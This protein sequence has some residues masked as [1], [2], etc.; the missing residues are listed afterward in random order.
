[1]AVDDLS[2]LMQYC[3]ICTR[4]LK[5]PASLSAMPKV[6]TCTDHGDLVIMN[7]SEFGLTMIFRPVE[8]ITAPE[9]IDGKIIT[10][11]SVERQSR[12]I[13][14]RCDQTG[15]VYESLADAARDLDIY[16][17]AISAQLSGSRKHAGKGY[18]FT[19]AEPD[20]K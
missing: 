9:I 11:I 5:L 18:T 8:N 17:A 7:S 15:Q 2:E 6:L 13:R 12:C 4:K 16:S 19:L 14:V 3:P 1:M 10:Y 20:E